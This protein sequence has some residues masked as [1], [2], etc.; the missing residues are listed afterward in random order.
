MADRYLFFG[1]DL[2]GGQFCLNANGVY[3]FDPETAKTDR[4]GSTLEDWAR[5]ILSDYEV[6]TGYPLG[7]QGNRV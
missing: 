5:A 7:H 6:L 4:I 3:H 2:F 1:E